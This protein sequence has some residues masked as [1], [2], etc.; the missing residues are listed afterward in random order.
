MLWRV[1]RP[2]R[3]SKVRGRAARR[4]NFAYQIILPSCMQVC[5]TTHWRT[6]HSSAALLFP[7][8]SISMRITFFLLGCTADV[9]RMTTTFHKPLGPSP[10]SRTS[11]P[12]WCYCHSIAPVSRGH[13]VM[14]LSRPPHA[15]RSVGRWFAVLAIL[16]SYSLAAS[17]VTSSWGLV[18]TSM[19]ARFALTI[20]KPK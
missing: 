6:S 14:A 16:S 11:V 7:S 10:I 20:I 3:S 17:H 9:S 1:G 4:C 19:L 8:G 13:R 12:S 5:P 18:D 2:I 15:A